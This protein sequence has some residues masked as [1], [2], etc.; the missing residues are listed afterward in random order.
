MNQ[1]IGQAITENLQK[2]RVTPQFS[3]LVFV[4]GQI[5]ADMDGKNKSAYI[6]VVF[7][8]GDNATPMCKIVL[9]MATATS[10]M[11][12]IAQHSE[13][14]GKKMKVKDL[15][16]QAKKTDAPAPKKKE[17]ESATTTDRETV[18]RYVR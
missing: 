5:N 6:K 12:L 11:K 9:P 17:K 3:E 15:A 8:D 1:G 7:M 2:S 14:L 13:E 16:K 18:A 4:S 10:L